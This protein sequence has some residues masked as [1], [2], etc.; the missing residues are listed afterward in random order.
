MIH[1]YCSVVAV[2]KHQL[3][4]VKSNF[5]GTSVDVFKSSTD[6]FGGKGNG[7][8]LTGSKNELILTSE[9]PAITDASPVTVRFGNL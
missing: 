9:K 4:S 8:D 5:L 7:F 3:P 2:E 6:C 1:L